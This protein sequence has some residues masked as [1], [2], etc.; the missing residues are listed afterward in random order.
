VGVNGAKTLRKLGKTLSGMDNVPIEESYVNFVVQLTEM[1]RPHI[2]NLVV[3]STIRRNGVLYRGTPWYDGAIW[4]DWVIVDWGEHGLL[5]N[6]I[7]GFVNL[8]AIPPDN[9]LNCGGLHPIPPAVYAIVESA[10]PDRSKS[11]VNSELF[12]PLLL[13]V[14]QMRHN[15]VTKLQFYLAD[16]EAFSEPVVVIPDI[17]GSANRYLQLKNRNTWRE[18]FAAW[19]DM[20]HEPI[21]QF[22]D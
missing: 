17:G 7:W 6:K 5:P 14:G 11:V 10:E 1:V 20:E 21:P 3:Y 18:D 22:D 8:S 12:I 19:L 4:R 2:P 16:V 15:R 9:D 13:E